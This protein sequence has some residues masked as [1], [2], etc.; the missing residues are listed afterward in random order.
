MNNYIAS[1]TIL[2]NMIIELLRIVTGL[3]LLVFIPGYALTWAFYPKMD[4]IRFNER[5]AFSFAISISIV[6]I[7][8]IFLDTV[9]GVDITPVNIVISIIFITI[10]FLVIWRLHLYLINNDLLL[11]TINK[12]IWS[13]KEIMSYFKLKYHV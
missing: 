8:V 2:L 1:K 3:F 6:M 5:I 11:K 12:M 10:L 13:I 9:L 4:D 7:F